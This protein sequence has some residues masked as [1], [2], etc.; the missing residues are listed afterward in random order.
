MRSLPLLLSVLFLGMATTIVLLVTALQRRIRE[1]VGLQ[2]ENKALSFILDA[3]LQDK[4]HQLQSLSD[5]YYYWT[6]ESIYQREK[7][8]GSS[9]KEEIIGQFRKDLHELRKHPHFISDI[10]NALNLTRGELMRRF[11]DSVSQ[12][13]DMNLKERDFELMVLFFAKFSNKQIGFLMSMS[14]DAVRQRKSRYRKLFASAG[15]I[16]SEYLPYLM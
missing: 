2:E 14:D 4:I 11:R 9:T 7:H 3:L 16:F 12:S 13:P 8:Q 15:E 1:V 5:T 6:E 10:E